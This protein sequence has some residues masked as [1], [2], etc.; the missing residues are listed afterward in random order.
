M[1]DY[2]FVIPVPDLDKKQNQ[3][4]SYLKNHPLY[5]FRL[6]SSPTISIKPKIPASANPAEAPRTQTI[7]AAFLGVAKTSDMVNN[8]AAM[9]IK[10]NVR[11]TLMVI[12][13]LWRVV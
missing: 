12:H 6:N 9:A 5:F 10:V 8:A 2:Q 11:L 7:M 3:S 1:S 4:L 13:G